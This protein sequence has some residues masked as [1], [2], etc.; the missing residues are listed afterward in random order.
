MPDTLTN[1]AKMYAND[2]KILGKICK[3]NQTECT[4]HMQSDINKVETW[5]K[6]WLTHLNKSKCKITQIGYENK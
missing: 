3:D 4:N 6:T 2:T 1:L 5:T